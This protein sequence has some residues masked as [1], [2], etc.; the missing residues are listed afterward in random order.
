MNEVI[1][2]LTILVQV[3]EYAKCQICLKD[4]PIL[5]VVRRSTKSDLLMLSFSS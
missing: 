1:E 4:V 3:E 2:G 5:C